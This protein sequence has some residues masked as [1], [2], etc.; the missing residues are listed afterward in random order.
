[1]TSLEAIYR[2][3]FEGVEKRMII[4]FTPEA[5]SRTQYTSL[6]DISTA[7]WRSILSP[8]NVAILSEC[9]TEECPMANTMED[10][11]DMESTGWT[12]YL[13]SE[14]SLFVRKR[15]LVLKTCGT[16]TPLLV[17][18]PIL[19]DLF[20]LLDDSAKIQLPDLT[21]FFIFSHQSFAF[22]EAQ[23]YPH[24]SFDE[25][26][27]FLSSFYSG[28]EHIQIPTSNNSTFYASL[29][30]SPRKGKNDSFKVTEAL[31]SGVSAESPLN[32]VDVTA[33]TTLRQTDSSCGRGRVI[34]GVSGWLKELMC[35]ADPLKCFAKERGD[36]DVVDEF[37][38][39]PCGYS[40]NG[41]DGHG[42]YVTTHVSPEEETSYASVESYVPED[43]G[44]AHNVM[45]CVAAMMPKQFQI[46]TI[47]INRPKERLT[48]ATVGLMSEQF[49]LERTFV[50]KGKSW[51]ITSSAFQ[52]VPKA[53]SS[54]KA[55]SP[56]SALSDTLTQ[57]SLRRPG[58]A[59]SQTSEEM[60][61]AGSTNG[62]ETPINDGPSPMRETMTRAADFDSRISEV[63]RSIGGP[64]RSGWSE[65]DQLKAIIE[66]ENPDEPVS[67][68]NVE[69]VVA[70]WNRWKANLPRVEPFY[71]VKCNDD[72]I[73]LR[74]LALLGSHFDCASP[75]EMQLVEKELSEI[76]YS[77]PCKS[78]SGLRHAKA[79]GIKL[80]VFDN[81][82]ELVKVAAEY[83]EAQLLLRIRTDDKSAQCPMSGKYGSPPSAWHS[84]IRRVKALGLNLVGVDFHVGS[85]CNEL[86]PFTHALQSARTVF[87]LAEAE[88]FDMRVLDLGGGF[89]GDLPGSCTNGPAFEDLAKEIKE[90]LESFP[91]TVRV[92][93]EPGRFFASGVST[94]AVKVFSRRQPIS[95]AEREIPMGVNIN[96]SMLSRN[97]EDPKDLGTEWKSALVEDDSQDAK[98]F[99]YINDGIYGS[100][101]CLIYDH[102]TIEAEI[103]LSN[104]DISNL[105]RSNVFGQTCD[106]LDCILK[107]VLLPRL[108]VGDWLMFRNMGAYTSSAASNFNGFAKPK[109]RY[110]RL[111]T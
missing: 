92:I 5:I 40:N 66:T 89:S 24:R 51:E 107:D 53:E 15:C 82:D 38:F 23:K 83:P 7:K 76:V 54:P 31:M 55:D 6:R 14:S 16:T 74:T 22:P 93:S 62:G 10:M 26:R 90:G 108:E 110:A 52:S 77:N 20:G 39:L 106:G 97:S 70:Q 46:L 56:S 49:D 98:A 64:V 45:P 2:T 34:R 9:K 13:L 57:S 27:E 81:E 25:E 65:S 17:L 21:S 42:S 19:E 4:Q 12:A 99:Y 79:C 78:V 32:G 104:A 88:G 100:F 86:G 105:Q 33:G 50:A 111:M 43:A 84:L 94:L 41:V 71:A 87:D 48:E 8:A 28:V 18:K 60:D 69:A 72:P 91:E 85:G 1:M 44:F 68:V 102:A 63:V 103:L 61:S 80:V 35:P 96:K 58:E 3:P 101:N 11:G 109:A 37:F 36:V 73:L 95:C 67:L 30:V 59:L 47:D 75:P 29:F